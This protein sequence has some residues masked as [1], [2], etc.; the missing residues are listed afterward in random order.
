MLSKLTIPTDLFVH[1]YAA[2]LLLII[3]RSRPGR[4]LPVWPE[5]ID[6][7][8]LFACRFCAASQ[9]KSIASRETWTY[10]MLDLQ[11]L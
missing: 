11:Q 10:D 6:G 4:Q 2:C 5:W 9:I 8:V 1:A 7:R 3:S